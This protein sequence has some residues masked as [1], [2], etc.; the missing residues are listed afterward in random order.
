MKNK[1]IALLLVAFLVMTLVG[2][3]ASSG[4]NVDNNVGNNA[5]NNAD[6]NA[7]GNAQEAAE[8]TFIV[9]FDQNFPPM[10]FVGDDGQYTGFDLELA[11]EAAKR[12]NKKLVLQPIDWAA[13]DMELESGNIDCVW[14]GFT[15]NG[16]EDSYTWTEP[17]M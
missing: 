11:A 9:G 12:L 14:N 13:K 10:G 2:C 7:A 1:L 6:N 3:T 4:N 8:D 17:Y 5:G 16:R 15:I